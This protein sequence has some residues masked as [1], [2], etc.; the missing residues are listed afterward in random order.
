VWESRDDGWFIHTYRYVPEQ[1]VRLITR[2][3]GHAVPIYST[4]RY[5]CEATKQAGK[6]EIRDAR[7]LLERDPLCKESR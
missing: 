5:E 1:I 4:P 3:D 2:S 7:R 6:K